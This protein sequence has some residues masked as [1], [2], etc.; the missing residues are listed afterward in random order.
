MADHL[1]QG[2]VYAKVIEDVIS[3]SST[4][5]EESG[6]SQS[7]LQELQKVS[8]MFRLVRVIPQTFTSIAIFPPS[9]H[10]TFWKT[11]RIWGLQIFSKHGRLHGPRYF[12]APAGSGAFGDRKISGHPLLFCLCFIRGLCTAP[13]IALDSFRLVLPIMRH[14][15]SIAL[16]RCLSDW[17]IF[18]EGKC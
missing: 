11:F 4:D 6:V 1:L 17:F 9:F 2:D 3:A 16:F 14:K 15:F 7:T 8:R 13:H 12:S 10:S 5:F 18:E